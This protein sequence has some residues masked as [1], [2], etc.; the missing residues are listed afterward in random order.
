M[1]ISIFMKEKMRD[2]VSI[3]ESGSGGTTLSKMEIP[4]AA[5]EALISVTEMA[6]DLYR[7]SCKEHLERKN[8]L[9]KKSQVQFQEGKFIRRCQAI[10][11]SVRF[12]QYENVQ[13]G[14]LFF[15][16]RH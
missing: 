13:R 15:G 5:Q 6:G 7:K 16:W 12:L 1:L 2:F 10:F 3:V 4:E 9:R 11:R 14:I 8:V